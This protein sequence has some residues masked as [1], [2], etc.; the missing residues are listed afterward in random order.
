MPG[1]G[2][3]A[4]G[5]NGLLGKDVF[6]SFDDTALADGKIDKDELLASISQYNKSCGEGREHINCNDIEIK[7]G[8]GMSG[9][10]LGDD[11]DSYNVD[12]LRE[13]TDV[14][15]GNNNGSMGIGVSFGFGQEAFLSF[16]DADIKDG[17]LSEDD[18]LA[19]IARYNNSIDEGRYH[20]RPEDITIEYSQGLGDVQL[21]DELTSGDSEN[22]SGLTVND[23]RDSFQG[24]VYSGNNDGSM[25]IGVS[26]SGQ[27]VFL[28]LT[29]ADIKDG[30]LSKDDISAAI[31]RYN[32]SID[33]GRYHIRPEDI[34]IEYSQGIGDVQLSDEFVNQSINLL[35]NTLAESI[36]NTEETEPTS[37]GAAEAPE[38]IASSGGSNPYDLNDL[39]LTS[40]S[41][42]ESFLDARMVSWFVLTGNEYDDNLNG[43]SSAMSHFQFNEDDSYV[44]VDENISSFDDW[45]NHHVG[46]K[47]QFFVG[48]NS[49]EEM[50]A[51]M[52]QLYYNAE[53]TPADN[54]V[55]SF[56]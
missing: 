21:S 43:E 51:A 14:Y 36:T 41:G 8:E 26:F 7:Y 52:K 11:L 47:D 23:M 37:S 19:A 38:P 55:Q 30:K 54:D 49:P 50:M 17:E 20:I 16:T 3:V 12:D 18:I 5:N 10:E 1:F 44:L 6:L 31:A 28:S 35:D 45:L 33:E 48:E 40:A 9:I 56:S 2:I 13:E 4:S 15:S 27:D 53:N 29:D 22:P 46:N 24:T 32:N 42:Q 25:G 34:T 39:M